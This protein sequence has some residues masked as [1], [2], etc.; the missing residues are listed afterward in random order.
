METVW[1]FLKKLNI[2][3]PSDL[4]ILFPEIYLKELKMGI[5][6]NTFKAMLTGT[7]FYSSQLV[8]T[9]QVTMSGQLDKQNEGYTSMKY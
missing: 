7:F 2:K 4:S 8:E 3:V 6:T 5:P 9:T 1:Q